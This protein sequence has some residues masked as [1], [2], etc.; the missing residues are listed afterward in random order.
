MSNTEYIVP[1][2]QTMIKNNEFIK[3]DIETVIIPDGALC[4]GNYAFQN[5]KNLKTVIIPE[6][7]VSIGEGAFE[8][9]KPFKVFHCLNICMNYAP[10][11]FTNVNR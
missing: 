5:C 9:A 7:V 4:I 6:S 8:A 10:K 2:M 1:K 3:S 11:P